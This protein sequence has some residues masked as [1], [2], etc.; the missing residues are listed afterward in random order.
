MWISPTNAQLKFSKILLNSDWYQLENE[1][2]Y[3]LY[4]DGPYKDYP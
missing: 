3:V 1:T 4:F 2:E